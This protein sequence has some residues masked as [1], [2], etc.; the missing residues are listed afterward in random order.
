MKLSLNKKHPAGLLAMLVAVTMLGGC[1]APETPAKVDVG[2]GFKVQK[3]FTH[4]GCTV[5]RFYDD[6]EKYFTR[7]DGAAASSA[8]WKTGSKV[9]THHVSMT[10]YVND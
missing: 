1:N 5:Y 7:C 9:K 8:Q 6:G 10:G 3:L 2:H 4:D